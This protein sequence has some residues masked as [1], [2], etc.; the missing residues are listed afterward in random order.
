MASTNEIKGLTGDI[1]LDAGTNELEILVFSIDGAWFGLNVAKVREVIKPVEVTASPNQHP[2][3]IGMFNIRG[4]VIPVV[5]L[6]K[7]LGITDERPESRGLEGRVIITEF[8]GHRTG[9]LVDRVDQIHRVS[10]SQ[11]KPAPDVNIGKGYGPGSDARPVS[12]T[13]G[14]LEIDG[15]LILMIDFESVADSILVDRELHLDV[16]DNPHGVDRKT[17]RVILAEDSPFMRKLIT[18]VFKRSGYE[19]LE[20][21]ADGLSAWEAVQRNPE[22]ID[23]LI[24]DIEMPRMDGLALSKRVKETPALSRIPILLFS[25]LISKDNIKKGKQVG[26]EVQVPKP[27]L[28]DMVLLV[29]KLVSGIEIDEPHR[30]LDEAA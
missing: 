25:S 10:W 8:N 29:D 19:K 12:S 6:A 11:V 23:A 28:E 30:T 13:T 16:V 3:V 17:K 14:T 20:T 21:F 1:L 26:V 5:D 15:C 9:F 7:H 22:T 4:H 27:K 2:S 18:D 24:S